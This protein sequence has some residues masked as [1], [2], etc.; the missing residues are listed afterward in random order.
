[1][2]F[3]YEEENESAEQDET[4]QP[5]L[6]T[7][8]DLVAMLEARGQAFTFAVKVALP[9]GAGIIDITRNF[10]GGGFQV[11]VGVAETVEDAER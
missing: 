11:I 9:G 5:Q 4:P 1:M 2:D 8:D 7:F 10:V 3:D 6:L